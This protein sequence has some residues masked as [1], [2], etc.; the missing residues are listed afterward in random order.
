MDD[1]GQLRRASL[2]HLPD[3]YL[4]LHVAR[5]MIVEVVQTDFAPGYDLG[6]LCQFGHPIEG[7]CVSQLR[8][9]WMNT[10]G[11]VHELILLREQNAAIEIR[12]PVA[13]PDRDNRLDPCLSS[14]SDDRLAVGVV[15]MS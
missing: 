6:P 13:I 14:A 4:L 7:C 5:R 15:A 11:R 1:D 3:E 8:F 9:M 12:R 2:L 10:D